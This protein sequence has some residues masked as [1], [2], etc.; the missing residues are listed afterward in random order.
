MLGSIDKQSKRKIFN[1]RSNDESHRI[2]EIGKI[3]N[4]LVPEA[5]LIIGEIRAS[6][7]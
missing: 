6:P 3:I 5:E 4:A 7:L 2:M 1:V